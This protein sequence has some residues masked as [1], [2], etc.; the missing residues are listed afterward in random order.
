M[1]PKMLKLNAQFDSP[2]DYKRGCKAPF[3]V[4]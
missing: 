1:P 4:C 3:L 2:I